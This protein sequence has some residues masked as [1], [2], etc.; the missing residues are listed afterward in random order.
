MRLR[1]FEEVSGLQV[2]ESAHEAAETVGGLVM[3]S[4]GRIPQLG[5]EVAIAGGTLRVEQ[6]DERRVAV[7][8]LLPAMVPPLEETAH[9]QVDTPTTG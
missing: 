9:R 7:V 3:A 6:M 2:T 4:L 5:D 1:D 8:R